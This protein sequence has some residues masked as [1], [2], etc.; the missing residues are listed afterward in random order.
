MEIKKGMKFRCIK[1]VVMESGETAYVKGGIYMSHKDNRI[2][3]IQ[4]DKEHIW[5]ICNY[6]DFFVPFNNEGYDLKTIQV[7]CNTQDEFNK[8]LDW[9]KQQKNTSFSGLSPEIYRENWEVCKENTFI[10]LDDGFQYGNVKRIFNKDDILL[11]YPVFVHD[12]IETEDWRK[13]T[14]TNTRSIISQNTSVKNDFIDGKLRWD[15]LPL[16]LIEELVK[17][18]DY[19]AK[20]YY[21]ESWKEIPDGYQ[22]LKAAALRHLVAFEKGETND[23]E[24][25]LSHLICAS[26]NLLTC[27]YYANE[28]EKEI[29]L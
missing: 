14:D 24:S 16:D 26:W 1:T 19:G 3:D 13:N 4:F 28:G 9:H 7:H 25:G 21:P 18:Y 27:Y 23:P 2:T 6:G 5:K 12:F 10:T 15:L 8:V 29:Q 22:R 11:S 17:V 20:K